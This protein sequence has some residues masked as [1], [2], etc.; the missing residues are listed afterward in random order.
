MSSDTKRPLSS[1]SPSHSYSTSRTL[2]YLEPKATTAPNYTPTLAEARRDLFK[3]GGGTQ[4]YGDSQAGSSKMNNRQYAILNAPLG[5]TKHVRIITIGGGASG[6]NLARTLQ[7]TLTSVEHVVYEKNHDVG[8]TWLENRY[9]GCRC[10][11]PSHN[12]QFSWKK[13]RDWTS[14]CST[15]SEI[16]QYLRECKDEVCKGEEIKL[17]HRVVGMVWNEEQG[18]WKVKVQ[19]NTEDGQNTEFEDQA[20]FVINAGGI[21]K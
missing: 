18:L 10:D 5:T 17:G 8:G 13:K 9:P 19:K 2:A 7:R 16:K 21:L 14:F 12:Y 15:A 1:L 11:I 4:P 3:M 6:I 20:N